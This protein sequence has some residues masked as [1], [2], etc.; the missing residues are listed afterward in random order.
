MKVKDDN[1]GVI[2]VYKQEQKE[3]D[4]EKQKKYKKI[5][6][7]LF[8]ILFIVMYIS[9]F[10]I[11]KI[12][13]GYSMNK[14]DIYKDENPYNNEI[15]QNNDINGN[16]IGDEFNNLYDPNNITN[17]NYA[18]NNGNGSSLNNRN[19]NSNNGN[20]NA[21]NNGDN[22]NGNNNGSNNGN[23]GS[24]NVNGG[25]NNSNNGSG[26][27]E[28]DIKEDPYPVYIKVYENGKEWKQSANLDIF[29]NPYFKYNNVIAPGIKHR[30]NFNIQ[31]TSNKKIMYFIRFKEENDKNVNLKYRLKKDDKYVLGNTNEWIYI[32]GVTTPN[33]I[34]EGK[35]ND[36]FTL[37]WYWEDSDRDTQ[38]GEDKNVK[39]KID[40]EIYSEVIK[41]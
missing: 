25:D 12:V 3:Q 10:F 4:N 5:N 29:N 37:D 30:Y 32:N 18:A 34:L 16:N 8:V 22:N 19:N 2:K 11:G 31:N 33:N 9:I 15:S 20:A 13:D 40:I 38:V 1:N 23:N 39:Y 36:N 35:E 7:A 28:D 6:I 17:N 41:E 24:T 27:E 21:S 26:N 14:T